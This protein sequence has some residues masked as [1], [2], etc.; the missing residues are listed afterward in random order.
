[1]SDSGSYRQCNNID[2]ETDDKMPKD[3]NVDKDQEKIKQVRIDI[4]ECMKP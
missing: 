4:Y 3:K 1:M 2:D